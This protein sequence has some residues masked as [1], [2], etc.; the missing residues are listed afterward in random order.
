MVAS[1]AMS[2][3]WPEG[4]LERMYLPFLSPDSANMRFATSSPERMP[5]ESASRRM[6][7]VSNASP[8]ISMMSFP[9][10]TGASSSSDTPT[11][12]PD[13]ARSDAGSALR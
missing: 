7:T 12:I 1:K 2:V 13:L 4:I 6:S 8:M 3:H 9:S 11:V 10:A 5:L